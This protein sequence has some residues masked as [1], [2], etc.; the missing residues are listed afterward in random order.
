MTKSVIGCM[1]D[2]DAPLSPLS[3]GL[4]AL[5]AYY[6]NLTD[7]MRQKSRD[8]MLDVTP[9]KIRSLKA[10]LQ[11]VIDDGAVCSIGNENQIKENAD[12][13]DSVEAL[14]KN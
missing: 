6:S 5:S 9:D 1:S 2:M 12:A 14:Y 4:R 10:L 11:S 8:E 3:K 7:E 13:F